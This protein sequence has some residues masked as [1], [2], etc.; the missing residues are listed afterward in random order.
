MARLLQRLGLVR[1]TPNILQYGIG[2][3]DEGEKAVLEAEAPNLPSEVR[4]FLGM[5]AFSARLI[6]DFATTAKPLR[7][8]D[9]KDSTFV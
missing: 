8:V 3:T 7:K 2:P 9:R 5:M 1:R 6:P 4:S